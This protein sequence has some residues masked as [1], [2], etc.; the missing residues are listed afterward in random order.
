MSEFTHR[1]AFG[2]PYLFETE[3]VEAAVMLANDLGLSFIELNTNFPDNDLRKLDPK[4]LRKLAVDHEVFFTL[5]LDDSM[6]F[7]HTNSLV[8]EAYVQTVIDA[9]HFCK[10]SGIE[11][12]NLHF[13]KGNIVTLPTGRRYINASYLDEFLDHVRAFRMR[14]EAE[15]RNSTI[16]LCIE[17]TEAWA[18][19][20]RRAIGILLDSPFFYLT[21]DTGHDHASHN[22]DLEFILEHQSKLT[23]M[24]LHDGI[25]QINHQALGTG[26]IALIE[27]LSLARSRRATV[28]IETKT[29]EAV[30]ASVVWLRNEGYL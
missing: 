29:K 4:W 8:R 18:A 17:N 9:I 22:V 23:H 6:D 30:E 28:L 20:E 25:D 27:R 1:L 7:A 15:L 12:I 10:I 16:K 13:A 26:E 11:R 3:S 21:L 19:H 24:H 5:H 2:L 14:C